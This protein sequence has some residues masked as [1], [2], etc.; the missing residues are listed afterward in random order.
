[1]SLGAL[2]EKRGVRGL[3]TEAGCRRRLEQL[4]I[5][6]EL[7]HTVVR[8]PK[9]GRYVVVVFLRQDQLPM[10]NVLANLGIFVMGGGI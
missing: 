5:A 6:S 2:T 1:M 8:Q 4:S 9:S 3:K 7:L 10:A